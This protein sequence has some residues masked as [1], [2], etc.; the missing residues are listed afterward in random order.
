MF[1]AFVRSCVML[2]LIL[3]A[4]CS[5]ANLGANPGSP[6]NPAQPGTPVPTE[7]QGE[8]RYGTIS[9]INY[10]DPATG[11]WGSP[12]GTGIYFTLS[13]DGNYERSSLLQVSS[14]GCESYVF[15]WE[16]GTVA[17]TDSQITF[18]PSQS[19]VKSQQC[20]ADNTSETRNTVEPETFGWTVGMDDYS[21]IV[22][23]LT[24]ASGEADH[25]DRPN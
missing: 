1:K 10:Y 21:E 2:P 13:S 19:A 9:S 16:V 25:Y 17:V 20:S 22:L 8:W 4:A 11:A 23:T 12:S 5:Q 24:Y 7:L 18:Q 15:V 3:L 14:Y 6:G